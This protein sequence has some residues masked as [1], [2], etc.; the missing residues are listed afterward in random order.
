MHSLI[1]EISKI[2]FVGYAC[3]ITS[4]VPVS[5]NPYYFF[6]SSDNHVVMS[7][8]IGIYSFFRELVGY[9]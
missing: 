7:C 5:I 3:M 1:H 9:T 8:C 4:L 2:L 6:I